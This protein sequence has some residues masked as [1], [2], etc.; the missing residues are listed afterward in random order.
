[1]ED[2]PVNWIKLFC[3]EDFQ[4]G[5]FQAAMGEPFNYDEPSH[6]YALGRC[7]AIESKMPF[8]DNSKQLP[9]ILACCPAAVSEMKGSIHRILVTET[10][11]AIDGFVW[12]ARELLGLPHTGSVT[13]GDTEH[14]GFRIVQR[15]RSTTVHLPR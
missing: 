11:G 3:N 9:A 8:P 13:A 15:R 5:W 6:E 10:I 1:M 12:L 2:I 14:A 4:R 7:F